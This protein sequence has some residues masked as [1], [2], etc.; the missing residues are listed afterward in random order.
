MSYASLQSGVSTPSDVAFLEIEKVAVTD[1][2]MRPFE[3]ATVVSPN[4]TVWKRTTLCPAAKF[5]PLAT[6]I[7]HVPNAAPTATRL[8]TLGE[9]DVIEG[10]GNG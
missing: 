9:Y 10:K 3:I 7:Q 5:S 2:A 6:I 4:V 8:T 1:Y